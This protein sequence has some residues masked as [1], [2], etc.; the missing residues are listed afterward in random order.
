MLR[1]IF[2]VGCHPPGLAAVIQVIS[3]QAR[4]PVSKVRLKSHTPCPC[5]EPGSPKW[6]GVNTAIFQDPLS[7]TGLLGHEATPLGHR[8]LLQNPFQPKLLSSGA[9]EPRGHTHGGT[10]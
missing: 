9:T 8:F 1:M 10:T 2:L 6:V 5:K 7:A 4:L 3:E